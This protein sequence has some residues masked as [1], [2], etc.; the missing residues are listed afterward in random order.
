MSYSVQQLANLAKV[1]IRTLHY[2]DQAGLLS[3][4]RVQNNGYRY[5]E[6]PE[7]LKL[8]QILFFR[9]LDFSIEE[10]KRILSSPRFDM[11]TA[12]GDQRGLI[13][14]K[15][16][17]LDGLIQTIDR[18]IKKINKETAMQDDE[19]YGNFSKEEM[20][21]YTEEAKQRW[22]HTETFKQSQERVQKMG[23]AGLTKALKE[24]GALTQ[25]IAMAM[26]SG[27]DPKSEGA[28]Q[29]IAKHYN[30]L[31]VFYEPNLNMYR[32]MAK[33]YVDDPRFKANYENVAAGLA[34]YMRDGMLHYA[35]IQEANKS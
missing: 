27:L 11:K 18:T 25:E 35:D 1:S 34:Q 21:K 13:Q 26:K 15:R 8:Q 16:T 4:A 3:P 7:L 20:D 30:G 6:E 14:I 5:Y 2:Y 28:Q 17:R 31:R 19:L 10:I 24:A 23:K 29:L 12:L 22:G 33:M 32:G 9:E